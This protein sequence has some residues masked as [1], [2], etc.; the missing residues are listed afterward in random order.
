MG[1]APCN[2]PCLRYRNLSQKSSEIFCL[3]GISFV[4]Q[5][6]NLQGGFAPH[7]ARLKSCPDTNR[8]ATAADSVLGK[9]IWH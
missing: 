2:P 3:S 4:L 8:N 9:T 6:A 5:M 7:A 1:A